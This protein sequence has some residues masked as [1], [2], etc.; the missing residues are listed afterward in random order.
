M[1]SNRIEKLKILIIII[2]NL[3]IYPKSFKF[4]NIKRNLEQIYIL[5]LIEVPFFNYF[6]KVTKSI[7]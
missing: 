3:R 2:I 6:N 4:L 7:N 5:K 1:K